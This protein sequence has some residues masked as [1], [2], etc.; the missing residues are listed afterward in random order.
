MMEEL[1][2]R[3]GVTDYVQGLQ[4]PG[5]TASEVRLRHL[6]LTLALLTRSNSLKRWVFKQLGEMFYQ[7]MSAVLD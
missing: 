4:T 7:L 1:Q 2:K 6:R 3:L 5:Q